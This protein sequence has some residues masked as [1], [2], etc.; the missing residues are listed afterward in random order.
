MNSCFIFIHRPPA[1]GRE[2][3]RGKQRPIA[4][5]TAVESKA[6]VQGGFVLSRSPPANFAKFYR[7]GQPQGWCTVQD[8]L[9]GS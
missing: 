4:I 6:V 3:E 2:R 9:L 5:G 7:G 8:L 1:T